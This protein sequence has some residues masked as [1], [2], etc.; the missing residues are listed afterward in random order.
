MAQSHIVDRYPYSEGN[1]LLETLTQK[2]HS[3]LE[4][5]SSKANQWYANSL[6]PIDFPR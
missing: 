4:R 2:S 1:I 6:G 3:E 5:T